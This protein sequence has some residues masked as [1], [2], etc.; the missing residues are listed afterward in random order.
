MDEERIVKKLLEHDEKLAELVTRREFDAFRGEYLQGQD[1]IMTILK[2][3]D[4][5]RIFTAQWVKRIERQVEEHTEQIK[6]IKLQLNI[7]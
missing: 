7:A 2:R 5:E 1:E 6:Q 3:L 4:Q